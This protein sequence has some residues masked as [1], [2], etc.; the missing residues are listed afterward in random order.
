[1]KRLWLASLLLMTFNVYAQNFT[2]TWVN[3]TEREDG[4]ELLQS[5][6]AHHKLRDSE[7]GTIIIDNIEGTLTSYIYNFPT[8]VYIASMTTVDSDGRE[9]AYSPFLNFE[10]VTDS[11]TLPVIV[12]PPTS[13]Q[14]VIITITVDVETTP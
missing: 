10:S 9:S 14:Q 4:S 7:T 1:M 12:E 3:A 13:P 6:I 8:G 2:L 5:D 11:E